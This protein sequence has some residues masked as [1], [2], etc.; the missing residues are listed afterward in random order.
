MNLTWTIRLLA[1]YAA[2]AALFAVAALFPN[3]LVLTGVVLLLGTRQHALGIIGHWAMHRIIPR[4]IMWASFIPIAIDPRVYWSSHSLHHWKLGNGDI[5]PEVKVVTKYKE[6]WGKLNAKVLLLDLMG[7]HLDETVDILR[8]LV[9]QRS[10][11]WYSALLVLALVV[12]G[13]LALLWPLATGSLLASHRIRAHFEHDHLNSP[14]ISFY[15]A[16]PAL[17]LRVLFLPHYAWKHA[18]HHANPGARVWNL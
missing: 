11:I 16:K 5:D 9:S 15:H 13:P 12:I 6:R 2:I 17:W 1:E 7:M 4:W 10:I 3:P 14:G 8:M 18:E